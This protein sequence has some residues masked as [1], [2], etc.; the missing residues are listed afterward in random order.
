MEIEFNFIILV[1]FFT[2][3]VTIFTQHKRCDIEIIVYRMF[4]LGLRICVPSSL[5]TEK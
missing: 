5:Y 3:D 1:Q 4:F 2:S